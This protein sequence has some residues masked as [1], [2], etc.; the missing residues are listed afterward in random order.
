MRLVPGIEIFPE[1][2][3][4]SGLMAL[5]MMEVRLSEPRIE[6]TSITELI[7]EIGMPPRTTLISAVEF[8]R[9]PYPQ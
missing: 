6:F 5:K 4:V 2:A 9:D 3:T 8:L 1:R 7:L